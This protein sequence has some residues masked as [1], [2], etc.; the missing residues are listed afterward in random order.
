MLI[1]LLSHMLQLGTN[2]EKLQDLQQQLKIQHFI[3]KI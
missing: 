2:Q 3:P 1:L